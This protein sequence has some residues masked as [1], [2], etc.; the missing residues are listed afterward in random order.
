MYQ[1]LHRTTNSGSTAVSVTA[2]SYSSVLFLTNASASNYV[3]LG[4][5]GDWGGVG[6]GGV[7]FLLFGIFG[8]GLISAISI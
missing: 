7:G 3:G 4:D 6:G 8:E 5:L 1:E 2:A